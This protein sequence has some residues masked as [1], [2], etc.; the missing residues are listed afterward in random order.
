MCRWRRRNS[1]VKSTSDNEKRLGGHLNLLGLFGLGFL[2][3]KGLFGDLI[4]ND[5]DFRG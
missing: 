3:S 5:L 1:F 2:L 4:I